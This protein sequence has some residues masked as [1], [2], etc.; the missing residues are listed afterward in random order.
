MKY[1]PESQDYFVDENGNVYRKFKNSL[2]KLRKNSVH[3]GY[4]SVAIRYKNGK[5]KTQYVHRIVAEM[6]IPNPE[7]KPVVNHINLI[8]HDNRVENLEWVTHKENNEHMQQTGANRSE[9]GAALWSIYTTEQIEKVC[10]FLQDGYRN[11]DI[12]KLT[13]VSRNDVYMIRSGQNWTHISSK[14]SFRKKSRVRKLSV[15]TVSWICKKILEGKTDIEIFRESTNENLTRSDIRH[16]R[17]KET[18]KDIVS[19]Y[20]N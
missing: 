15:E 12:E 10:K 1:I 8:K 7:N 5:V 19:Q 2:R 18:Y 11:V 16:I 13:G 3:T 9:C 4:E 17:E 20:L 14:Y 6:F